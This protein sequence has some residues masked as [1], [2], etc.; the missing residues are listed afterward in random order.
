MDKNEEQFTELLNFFKTMADA[1]RLKIVGLLAHE[2]LS[3]EQIAEILGLHASTVSH[4]LSKL[5]G[6]GLVSARAESYYSV[7]Q[8]E[9]KNLEGMAKRLLSSGTL[10]A[11]AADMDMEAYDRKVLNTFIDVDGRFKALPTQQKKLEVILRYIVEK[12]FK[13][14]VRYSEK[15]VTEILAGFY[16]DSAGL[17]RDLVDFGFMARGRDGGAYWL[18]E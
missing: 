8:L 4:H 3:V 5:R 17:R 18:V 14:Q 12:A 11:V 15:E 13:S 9:T 10:P 7:Y 16:E 6:A 2:L 1:N